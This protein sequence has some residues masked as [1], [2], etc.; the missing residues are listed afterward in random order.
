M[1]ENSPQD[2]LA[3]QVSDIGPL[4]VTIR[5]SAMGEIG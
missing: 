3:V 2:N 1:A 5:S 4:Q